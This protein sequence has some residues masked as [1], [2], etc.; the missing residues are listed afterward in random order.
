MA[1]NL[2]QAI[3]TIKQSVARHLTTEAIEAASRAEGYRWRRRELGPAETVRAFLLQVLDGNAA[4]AAAVRLA[5]LNCSA[6]AYGQ[7]RARLPLAVFTR[8]L[9]RTSRAARGVGAE[10]RWRGHRT[11]LIDGSSFSMP[12]TPELQARFG[13]HANQ[14]PGCGFPIAHWLTLFDAESGLLLKQLASPLVTHDLTETPALH[15]ELAAG[16]VLVGDSAFGS[17]AHLARL[18]RRNLHGLFRIDGR[19]LVSFRGDRKLTGKRRRRITATVAGSR[20][21]RKLGRYDQVVEYD[22]PTVRSSWM[23]A[24]AYAELPEK[25]VVRELRSWTKQRRGRTHV[26]TLVTTLVD[27][28]RYPAADLAALYG[29]RWSVETDLA[30]LKTTMGLR[31]LRCR[32]VDGVLKEW[33][34]FALVY[35]LVR[36]VMLA[37]ART[38]SVHPASISFVDALRWLAQACRRLPP[39]ELI[40]NRRRPNRHEP[41]VRKRRPKHYPW[42]QQPRSKLRQR[43]GRQPLT[44]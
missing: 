39:L 36:L 25:I 43:L 24:A 34:V 15:A 6:E 11:F 37:A 42:M 38:Q 5:D 20:L 4:C 28:E 17:Y 22:K 33:T 18:L 7:A 44:T 9:E 14:A 23:T 31:V 16:D 1:L 12:D 40:V 26:V 41:R 30:H 13:Q 35:N 27:P 21:V 29:R 19:R 8:L 32:S 2:I 3:G 10:S